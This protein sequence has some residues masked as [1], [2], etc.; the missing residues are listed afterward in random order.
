MGRQMPPLASNA[1]SSKTEI[2]PSI[3]GVIP[4]MQQTCIVFE[5]RTKH[6]NPTSSNS[7]KWKG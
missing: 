7:P 5:E 3:P 2:A 4:R 1:S 6:L